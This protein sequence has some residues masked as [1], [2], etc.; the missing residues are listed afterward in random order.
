MPPGS[1]RGLDLKPGNPRADHERLVPAD[2][3]FDRPPGAGSGGTCQ[4][5]FHDPD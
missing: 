1:L 4:A 2:V 3:D 5:V